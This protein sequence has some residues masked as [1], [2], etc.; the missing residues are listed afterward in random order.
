MALQYGG[1][2]LVHRIEGYR[3]IAP[4]KSHSRDIMQTLSRYFS[5]TFSGEFGIVSMFFYLVASNAL[6]GKTA[7][8]PLPVWAMRNRWNRNTVYPKHISD[9]LTSHLLG[10]NPIKWRQ[11]P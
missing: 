4:W 6:N 11:S 8:G 7:L 1:S 10:R 2:Q 3:K 5:N 9:V